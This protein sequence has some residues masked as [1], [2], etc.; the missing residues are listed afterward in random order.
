MASTYPLPHASAQLD[1][2]VNRA[3]RGHERVVLT[4]EGEP[5]AVLIS[6][7]ELDELQR[8]QDAADIAICEAAVARDEP[9][10]AHEEFMAALEREDGETPRP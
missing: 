2:L 4:E 8:A 9:G 3:R 10:V 5:V 6:V 1:E 7:D